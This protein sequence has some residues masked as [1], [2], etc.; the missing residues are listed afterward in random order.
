[1]NQQTKIEI[2][3]GL[4]V[5]MALIA[6]AVIAF[7]VSNFQGLKDRPTY[8]V[9]ALFMNI[10]G[11]KERAPVKMSGVLVGR[12]DA[13]SI[14]PKTF[15]ARVEMKIFEKYN[16][17]PNDTSASILTSGLLGDQYIGLDPGAGESVLKDGSQITMTQSALI[18][19]NL[20]GKFLTNLSNKN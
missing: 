13:I 15:Q 11:L 4:F 2:W 18:L 8:Q 14:D 7:K 6:L 10:G 20:I 1:M 12:V 9:S 19:E 5:T 3:V 17:L 16:N